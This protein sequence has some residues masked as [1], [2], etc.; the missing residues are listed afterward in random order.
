M[1]FGWR[2]KPN[3]I[4]YINLSEK[5]FDEHQDSVLKLGSKH[6]LEEGRDL[7]E[8]IPRVE[9]AIEKIPAEFRQMVRT[10]YQEEMEKK[11]C[12]KNRDGEDRRILNRIKRDSEIACPH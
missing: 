12:E 5:R 3:E 2:E 6:I 8:T 1:D 9:T 4:P 10:K 7:R 11:I